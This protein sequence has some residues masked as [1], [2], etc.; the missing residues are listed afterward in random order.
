MGRWGGGWD[1]GRGRDEQRGGRCMADRPAGAIA[2]A[3]VAVA[4]R[5]G[6]P[7]LDG[8]SLTVSCVCASGLHA[9]IRATMMIQSGEAERVLV[10]AAEA[11]VHPMFVASF[12]RLGVLPPEA[13]DAGRSMCTATVS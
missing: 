11:S 3:S 12:K 4:V 13:S 7:L 2:F 10:V 6:F 8:P 5:E 1:G 9:L